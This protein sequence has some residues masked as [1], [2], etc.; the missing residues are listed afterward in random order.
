MRTFIGCVLTALVVV[1]ASLLLASAMGWF[2]IGLGF[3]AGLLFWKQWEYMELPRH[4][5]DGPQRLDP[6]L[7]RCMSL[8]NYRRGAIARYDNVAEWRPHCKE[9]FRID[10]LNGYVGYT[11]YQRQQ[12]EYLE[13]R[14]EW[15]QR[16]F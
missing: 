16:N 10:A 11:E 3:F 9:I 7:E 5:R 13:Q 2:G 4:L 12:Q 6:D 1:F 8:I 14:R 15:A